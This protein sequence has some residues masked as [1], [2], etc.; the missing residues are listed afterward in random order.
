MQLIPV[1]EIAVMADCISASGLFGVS[2]RDQSMA[3][4]LVAQSEGRH[5]ASAAKEYHIIKGRPSLKADA[6]LA[7]FQAAGGSVEW[8]ERTETC[9][10][11]TFT[12]PQGGSL[13]VTWK[14]EDAKRAGLTGDNWRKYPRH[15]L[16][17]RV[18]SEGV[19][20]VF[21]AVVSG[22]Y[23]P[24]E[25]QEF[26]TP[27]SKTP[28]IAKP[29]FT[30]EETKAEAIEIE[31]QEVVETADPAAGIRDALWNAMEEHAL[32]EKEIFAF[33]KDKMTPEQYGNAKRIA[34]LPEKV[35]QRLCEKIMLVVNFAAEHE[36]D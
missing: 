29:V 10:T 12:H 13:K 19:R 4:M 15:M 20:A 6:M 31:A 35:A 22:F 24:E 32:G 30:K 16:S 28:V 7:R 36:N 9:V 14:M 21:P 33:L 1:N 23:T 27:K 5:P 3:L 17:A 11:A 25:V 34:E 2:T 8:N 26:E 18:I